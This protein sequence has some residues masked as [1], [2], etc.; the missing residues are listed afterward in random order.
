M[1]CI[2]AGFLSQMPRLSQSFGIILAAMHSCAR[3]FCRAGQIP[4]GETFMNNKRAIVIAG[5]L[6]VV[7]TAHAAEYTFRPEPRDLNDLDHYY[8]YTWGIGWSPQNGEVITE[9]TL[10]F[11][12]IYDWQVEEDHLYIHLLDSADLGVV[13]HFDDQGDGDAFVGQGVLIDDWND[14]NGGNDTGFDLVYKFTDKNLIGTLTQYAQ[15]GNFGFGIDPDCHY[16]NEG[17]KFVIQ[18][19]VVPEPMTIAG[20]GVAGAALLSRRLRKTR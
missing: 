18:T 16:F 14:P 6:A 4:K 5:V 12:N 1:Y 2:L 8:N 19:E 11:R 7:G 10:S 20:L 9:A 17:V 3:L 15:D 13:E